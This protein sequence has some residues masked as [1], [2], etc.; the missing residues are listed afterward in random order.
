M[1]FVSCIPRASAAGLEAVEPAWDFG[2]A[3]ASTV[4]LHDFLLTN[5]TTQAVCIRNVSAACTCTKASF[6]REPVP[7]AGSTT[8]HASAHLPVCDGPVPLSLIVEWQAADGSFSNTPVKIRGTVYR[9]F[10]LEPPMVN[11]GVRPAGTP[12]VTN[13]VATARD[14]IARVEQVTSDDPRI[15]A[16]RTEEGR[17]VRVSADTAAITGA[18]HTLLHATLTNGLLR[19][20]QEIPFFL[21]VSPG[22]ATS[23]PVVPVLPPAPANVPPVPGTT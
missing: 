10:W 11:M 21:H 16:T 23:P 2:R 6:S 18:C 8:V 12:A 9:R 13:L 3:E 4:L 19:R 22:T 7:P 20:E 5:R 15:R 1:V 14:G 17:A